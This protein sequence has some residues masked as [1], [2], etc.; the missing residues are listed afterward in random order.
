MEDFL[1]HPYAVWPG[2]L[3]AMTLGV[4]GNPLDHD[5]NANAEISPE[6]LRIF[7]DLNAQIRENRKVTSDIVAE[8]RAQAE[9]TRATIEKQTNVLVRIETVLNLQ[10]LGISAPPT[11]LRFNG[12]SI[13]EYVKGYGYLARAEDGSDSAN[14]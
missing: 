9:A 1:R 6:M 13:I 3:L 14:R 12:G 4:W 7:A 5:K 11:G 10:R 8:Y 2:I